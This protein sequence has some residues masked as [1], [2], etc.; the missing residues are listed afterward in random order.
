MNKAFISMKTEFVSMKNRSRKLIFF[1]TLVFCMSITLFTGK[2]KSET[3]HMLPLQNVVEVENYHYPD[4]T[5]LGSGSDWTIYSGFT[6]EATGQIKAILH[7]PTGSKLTGEVWLC[8]DNLSRSIVGKVSQFTDKPTEVSWFLER[9]TY[10]IFAK[11]IKPSQAVLEG[12]PYFYDSPELSI[13][14]LF[15]KIK[16]PELKPVTSFENSIY[17]QTND[18]ARGFLTNENP[19]DYYSFSLA[20]QATVKIKYA[21]DTSASTGEETGSCSLYD[22]NWISLKKGNYVKTDEALSEYTYLLEA[23]IYYVKLSGLLGNTTLRIEPMYYDIKLIPVTD[24][25]WTK[26]HIKVNI[27]TSIDY[28]DI[29]VLL[30]NVKDSLI[31]NDKVWTETNE[32]YIPLDGETFLAEKSGTY[33]VRITDQYGHNT[34]KRLKISNIDVTKPKVKGVKNQKAYNKAVKPTWT[35]TQSG[36]NKNK[37]TLNDKVIS[38]GTRITKEG[39]YILKVYDKIGNCRTVEFFIDYSKPSANVENGKTYTSSFTLQ[40]KDSTSGIKKIEIDGEEVPAANKIKYIYLDG[41]YTVELWDNADNHRKYSFN[42]K[43][44]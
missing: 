4:M 8:K 43:K 27:D 15:E 14:L 42:L 16:L 5:P 11:T 40:L 7:S 33:T 30:M 19:A 29:K 20:K 9:G 38:S 18:T 39:K 24:K 6:I 12:T 28:K 17:I 13:A 2:A 41:K 44:E 10:Y 31:D 35:D 36:L 21:F 37:T 25:N 1:A 23:G 34:M 32:H 3:S 22:S 26:K